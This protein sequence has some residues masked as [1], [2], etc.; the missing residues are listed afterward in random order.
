MILY[1]AFFSQP[2]FFVIEK[3]PILPVVLLITHN[4]NLAIIYKWI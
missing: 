4:H 2:S 3:G 1:C